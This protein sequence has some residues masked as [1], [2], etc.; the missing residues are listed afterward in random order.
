MGDE[1]DYGKGGRGRGRGRLIN[2]AGRD[3]L[4]LGDKWKL[5]R[6]GDVRGKGVG[7]L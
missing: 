2:G 5:G 3:R 6:G 1:G 4:G 7:E